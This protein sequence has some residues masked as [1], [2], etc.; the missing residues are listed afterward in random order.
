MDPNVSLFGQMITFLIFVGVVMKFIWPPLMTA[1]E[2]RRQK[3]AD[4]LAA[5]ERG[6]QDLAKAESKVDELV[7]EARNQA[8]EILDQARS[9]ANEIIAEGKEEGQRERERQLTA[10]QA[11]IEQE[12][13]R[14][15]EDLRDQVG[16]LALATASKILSR[17]I[18]AGVHQDLIGDLAKQ[19]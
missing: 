13:N 4:G 16:E 19:I 8:A 18:D 11:E 17:E 6:Q 3:I 1:V 15:R 5:A 9:R 7:A 12:T 14:A 2:E 10:A